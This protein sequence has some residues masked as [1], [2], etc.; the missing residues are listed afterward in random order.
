M[1]D[2][3]RV[4]GSTIPGLASS[5]PLPSEVFEWV[6]KLRQDPEFAAMV[7]GGAVTV[8]I[9]G[10]L[11][12]EVVAT[13]RGWRALRAVNTHRDAV[14]AAVENL[15]STVDDVIMLSNGTQA[16]LV[17]VADRLVAADTRPELER[18]VDDALT[19]VRALPFDKPGYQALDGSWALE[20]QAALTEQELV[21][22]AQHVEQHRRAVDLV[23]FHRLN[24]ARYI[25][26]LLYHVY[27]PRWLSGRL[28]AARPIEALAIEPDS[29]G[30]AGDRLKNVHTTNP[31]ADP[32]ADAVGD[33]VAGTDGTPGQPRGRRGDQLEE[34]YL[35]ELEW[36]DAV[37][38]DGSDTTT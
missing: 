8:A 27:T 22:L 24:P 20:E 25:H 35:T 1:A 38:D 32:A 2:N 5:H 28:D 31:G 23:T 15:S 36:T 34:S 18:G 7:A 29:D 16:K 19:T 9:L 30:G 11:L 37:D 21:T 3:T 14:L 13:Y 17:M 10:V 6:T 12:V 26:G 33:A 4:A